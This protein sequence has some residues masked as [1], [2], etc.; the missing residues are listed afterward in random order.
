MPAVDTN[1]L[2]RLLTEDDED[3]ARQAGTFLRTAG[4][5]F[6]SHVVLVET[7]W[8]LS[9]VY[10]LT[11]EEVGRTLELL[12]AGESFKI[13]RPELAAEALRLYRESSADFADCLILTT[14]RAANEL[15]L[16]TF[17]DRAGR[18]AGARR[19]GSKRKR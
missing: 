9:S 10:A 3:Q 16:A 2:V 15:P 18:L 17:D 13:E 8:V 12:F 1:V 6:V 4:R 11:R 14:A 7:T 5:V 19:L